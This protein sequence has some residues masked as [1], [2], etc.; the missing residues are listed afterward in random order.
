MNN[1][2]L[3][4]NLKG[5]KSPFIDNKYGK[6]IVCERPVQFRPH[7]PIKTYKPVCKDCFNRSM[8]EDDVS[9]LITPES[10]KELERLIK[11]N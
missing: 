6:C 10:V 1:Q 4:C 8:A 9:V 2:F 7:A 11:S 3:I 5:T